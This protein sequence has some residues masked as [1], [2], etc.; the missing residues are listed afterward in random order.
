AEEVGVAFAKS[1]G[2]TGNEKAALD[3]LRALPAERVVNGLNLAAMMSPTYSGP[4]IDGTLVVETPEAALAA[5]REMR[6]P[7]IAGANSADIGFSVGNTMEDVCATFG[8][9]NQK[10]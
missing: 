6:I 10:A 5:G 1:V 9:E 3:A 7:V 4:M 2:I 8:A